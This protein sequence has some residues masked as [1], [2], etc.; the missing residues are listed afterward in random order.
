MALRLEIFLVLAALYL[1]P[2]FHFLGRLRI[3]RALRQ[4]CRP[5]SRSTAALVLA[6]LTNHTN[7]YIHTE[8]HSGVNIFS[9]AGSGV[10]E[11]CNFW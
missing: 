10:G 11:R 7:I 9:A 5:C 2:P 1:L 4:I 6:A 3:A 8:R